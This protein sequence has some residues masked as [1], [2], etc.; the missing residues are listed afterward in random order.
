MTREKRSRQERRELRQD[1][2]NKE[3]NKTRL[4]QG[5]RELDKIETREKRTRR[6]QGTRI[7]GYPF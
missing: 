5:R 7:S 2:D 3:V 6:H 4:R 1:P